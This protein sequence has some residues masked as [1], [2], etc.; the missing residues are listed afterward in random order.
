[1]GKRFVSGMSA[2][3]AVMF[4][5]TSYAVEW[6]KEGSV[7]RLL[8][9][10]GEYC[11]GQWFYDGGKQ[12]YLDDAGYMSV[13]WTLIGDNWYYFETDGALATDQWID[14][15]YVD[16]T[17]KMLTD[18]CT[19][20]GHYVGADGVMVG[21]DLSSEN[22]YVPVTPIEIKYMRAHMSKDGWISPNIYFIN[23]SGKIIDR[24]TFTVTPYDSAHNVVS[25]DVTG[26]S[27]VE[28]Y[29]V[30]PFNPDYPEV[31]GKYILDQD[32]TVHKADPAT[33]T[34]YAKTFDNCVALDRIWHGG[35]ISTYAI[36]GIGI[37]YIDGTT[38]TVNPYDVIKQSY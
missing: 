30:G 7:W 10:K 31:C 21:A 36:V 32:G 22:H 37:R 17:G 25:C 24:I 34:D 4:S 11:A 15:K 2:L 26:D 13:G 23:S 9:N 18:T 20:D 3:F 16:Y 8:N 33:V 6:K 19:K 27:T 1:M 28:K 14:Y 5:F 12:Y 29:V 35:N 38:E